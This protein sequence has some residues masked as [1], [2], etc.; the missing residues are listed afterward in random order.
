MTQDPTDPL[1][2]LVASGICHQFHI[3]L[4]RWKV[5][6]S[7]SFFQSLHSFW[8][9]WIFPWLPSP[10]SLLVYPYSL[11]RLALICMIILLYPIIKWHWIM[12]LPQVSVWAFLSLQFLYSGYYIHINDFNFH[13]FTDDLQI[14]EYFSGTDLCLKFQ[15]HTT[16]YLLNVPTLISQS[17][18]KHNITQNWIH[19]FH[20]LGFPAMWLLSMNDFH[21][22]KQGGNL[23]IILD[24][25]F[26]LTPDAYP[27][28]T[29]HWSES[30]YYT[31]S[32]Q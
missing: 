23:R 28:T 10:H 1:Y 19:C 32:L 2:Q 8:H 14:C 24:T 5:I 7:G 9:G 25:S 21:S 11:A 31:T 30:V 4:R 17:H 27:K 3:L 6:Y 22:G 18:F 29:S 26:S 12:K 15:T 13:L 16:N 20:L